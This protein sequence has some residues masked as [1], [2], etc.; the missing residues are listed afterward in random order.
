M[1]EACSYMANYYELNEEDRLVLMLAAWF[2][3]VGY[4]DGEAAGHEQ[5]SIDIATHF[6]SGQSVDEKIVQ[7]VASAIQATRMPQSP[8]NQVEKI[9]CDGDLHHLAT[10]DFKAKSQLLRQEREWLLGQEISKK[11]WNRNN[12]QFL[13]N[14][15]YFTEYGQEQLEPKKLENLNSLLKKKGKK[16]EVKKQKRKKHFLMYLKMKPKSR[17]S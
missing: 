11:D 1:V 4:K 5:K 13:E 7:R 8:V 16:E 10:E 2:H 9:L 3:D 12:I 17:R 6:L 14:H 15:K